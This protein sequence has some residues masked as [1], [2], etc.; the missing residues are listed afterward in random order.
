[1]Q[2]HV[3]ENL[4]RP[5]SVA[6]LA[7]AAGTSRRQLTRLCRRMLHTTP[8][9]YVTDQKLQWAAHLLSETDLTVQ[10]IADAVGFEDPYYFSRR[11]RQHFGV[12]PRDHRRGLTPHA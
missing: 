8:L 1:M 4:G 2:R 5:M 9:G 3:H 12:P 10:Q 11:F 7:R 6:E